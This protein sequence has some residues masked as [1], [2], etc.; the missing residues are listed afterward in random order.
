MFKKQLS[1]LCSYLLYKTTT[2]TDST[3]IDIKLKFFTYSPMEILILE[4]GHLKLQLKPISDFQHPNTPSLP[5]SREREV[6]SYIPA[7]KF[8]LSVPAFLP[9][10]RPL[11][12][13]TV[14][15]GSS[16][17]FYTVL[18]LLY[19]VT[20]SWTHSTTAGLP[21]YRLTSARRGTYH[22]NRFHTRIFKNH[23]NNQTTE[24]CFKYI[25]ELMQHIEMSFSG[26]KPWY[27]T[28]AMVL[29]SIK[30]LSI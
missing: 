29:L 21:H 11:S 7:L 28:R 26:K 9:P 1:I 10:L 5:V 22:T 12:D 19:R 4:T 23:D 15:P 25:V 24:L 16:D 20:T 2:W 18:Q 6:L 30:K 27:R 8:N 17:P 13:A 14:C 3:I